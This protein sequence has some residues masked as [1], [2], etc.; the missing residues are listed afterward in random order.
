MKPRLID[1]VGFLDS[2][3]T[4]RTPARLFKEERVEVAQ[5]NIC[6]SSDFGYTEHLYSDAPSEISESL[7]VETRGPTEPMLQAEDGYLGKSSGLMPRSR[8]VKP[9]ETLEQ[10]CP[11]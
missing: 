2:L 3:L 1:Q 7:Q 8:Y 5:N 6:A 4:P 10:I 11:S 9:S